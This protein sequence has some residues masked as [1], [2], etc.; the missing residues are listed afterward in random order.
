M[1]VQA[2]DNLVSWAKLNGFSVVSLSGAA[3]VRGG[4][5]NTLNRYAPRLV[6][7]FG[8]GSEGSLLGFYPPGGLLKAD[9]I[10]W[11]KSTPISTMACLSAKRLGPTAYNKGVP[12]YYGSNVLMYAAFSELEHN[13]LK[14]WIDCETILPKMLL[15]KQTF[16]MALQARRDKYTEYIKLYQVNYKEWFNA[17]W[18]IQSSTSN[19]DLYM[20]IGNENG[21]LR[22]RVILEE[23]VSQIAEVIETKV[24][25]PISD[26]FHWIFGGFIIGATIAA[27]VLVPIA[28]EVIADQAEKRGYIKKKKEAEF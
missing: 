19:R 11:L 15:Q 7:Y 14:D 26:L 8:H 22:P 2:G 28:A 6:S 10:D 24:V 20:L 1:S 16:G 27:S 5:A 9:N 12:Q 4:L 18:Y 3:A 25:K 21:T 13:Y 17:D 23:D